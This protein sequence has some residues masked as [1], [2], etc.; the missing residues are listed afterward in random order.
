MRVLPRVSVVIPL[1]NYARYI[2]VC[3][4]SVLAQDYPD[5]EVIVVDDASTDDWRPVVMPLASKH[6]GTL[7]VIELPEN[8]GYSVA[9]NEAIVASTG[10]LIATIDADDLLTPYSLMCRADALTESPDCGLVHARANSMAQ[11]GRVTGIDRVKRMTSVHAQ[12]VMIRRETYRRF[13]L[14]DELLRSK[15]DTEMWARLRHCGVNFRFIDNV[16][17]SYRKHPDSMLAERSRDS[18]LNRRICEAYR[19]RREIRERDGITP[20]N[21]R[22]LP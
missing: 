20:E 18:E 19:V 1:F 22:M 17:A 11:N 21:T 13:G 14:Y 5:F 15:A 3:L 4:E 9:K 12:T 6:A 16:V 2:G 7:Q 10:Q 8:R